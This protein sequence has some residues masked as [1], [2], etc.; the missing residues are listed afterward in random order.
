MRDD[1]YLRVA[2]GIFLRNVKIEESVLFTCSD[3]A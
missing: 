1:K 3:W 2:I